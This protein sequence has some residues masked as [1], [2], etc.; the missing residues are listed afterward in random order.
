MG[1]HECFPVNMYEFD[2]DRE[3]DLKYSFANAWQYWIGEDAAD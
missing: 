1:N 2:S 3:L